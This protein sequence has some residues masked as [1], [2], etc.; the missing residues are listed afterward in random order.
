MRTTMW[1]RLCVM[2]RLWQ[3]WGRFP[4]LR[5]GQL[6]I[7]AMDSA[8]HGRATWPLGDGRRLFYRPDV[9]LVSDVEIYD[10]K[11]RGLLK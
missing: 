5:L 7:N 8:E 1:H 4:H 11:R 3:L 10:L 6:I 2:V 9:F